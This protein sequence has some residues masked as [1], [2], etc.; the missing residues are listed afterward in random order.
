MT[1]Q[2]VFAVLAISGCS[3]EADIG[4]ESD[5]IRCADTAIAHQQLECPYQ[6]PTAMLG[7]I[8]YLPATSGV[9]YVD[10]TANCLAA[11]FRVDFGDHG[12][13]GGWFSTPWQ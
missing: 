2:L 13:V 9:M 12:A 1:K 6:V 4:V 10:E 3:D 5:P 11:R 7:Q 8:E